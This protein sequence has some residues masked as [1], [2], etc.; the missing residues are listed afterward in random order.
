MKENTAIL[1]EKKEYFA[2]HS[3]TMAC[4]RLFEKNNNLTVEQN[5]GGLRISFKLR[6]ISLVQPLL[7]SVT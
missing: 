4:K 1:T 7:L 6:F 3:M 2:K 5:F